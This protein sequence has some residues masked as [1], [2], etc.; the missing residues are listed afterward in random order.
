MNAAP[1]TASSP[2]LGYD[3]Q[4]MREVLNKRTT[5]SYRLIYQA[6]KSRFP[7]PGKPDQ[8]IGSAR[9]KQGNQQ[10]NRPRKTERRDTKRI[11]QELKLA[12]RKEKLGDTY[13]Q[14]ERTS[15]GEAKEMDRAARSFLNSSFSSVT[16]LTPRSDMRR[17][18]LARPQFIPRFVISAPVR[19]SADHIFD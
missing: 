2:G 14:I 17:S 18:R 19:V 6:E 1:S 3:V 15:L 5:N 12:I 7:N 11:S 16:L 13:A 9:K 4:I 10:G 8:V